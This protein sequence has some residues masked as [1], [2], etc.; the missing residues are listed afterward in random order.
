M[1]L[2]HIHLDNILTTSY[3]RYYYFSFYLFSFFFLFF[4][5]SSISCQ[6]LFFSTFQYFMRIVYVSWTGTLD[7]SSRNLSSQFVMIS[8]NNI[9]QY[10]GAIV[11]V[12]VVV[13]VAVAVAVVIMIVIVIIMMHVHLIL[14]LSTYTGLPSLFSRYNQ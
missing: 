6:F 11:T 8:N 14:Q 1:I 9:N 2:H 12:T 13:A 4:S 5:I 3:Q 7:L 10:Y